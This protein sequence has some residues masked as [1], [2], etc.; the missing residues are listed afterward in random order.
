VVSL[1][2]SIQNARLTMSTAVVGTVSDTNLDSW[3]LDLAPLGSSTFTT[4][5]TG[6][7]NVSAG[8]L[9]QLDPTTLANG[10]Y[11]LRLTASHMTGRVSTV[12]TITEANPA[13]KPTR[14]LRSETDLTVTLG[15]VPFS[16]VR[17]YD[18]LAQ[19]V[20]GSL[21][22]GWRLANADFAIQTNVPPTGQED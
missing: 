21:G 6:T 18:S 1:A 2:A 3:T 22:Y 14:Y 12:N 20:S 15:G 16:L 8:N 7:T 9:A 10:S 11:V 5:A 19:G 13:T 4:L 17:Q